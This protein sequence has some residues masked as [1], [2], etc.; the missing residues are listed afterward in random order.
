MQKTITD[1]AKD[2]YNARLNPRR[3]SELHLEI[4][5]VYASISDQL[6]DVKIAKAQFWKKKKEYDDGSLR[7]K[8]LSDTELE[9]QWYREEAGKDEIRYKSALDA[10]DKLMNAIKS[11]SVSNAIEA[12]NQY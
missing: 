10:L 3:L 7:E 2:V 1:Y 11:A 5:S 4:S 8:P 9:M 12:K 6:K